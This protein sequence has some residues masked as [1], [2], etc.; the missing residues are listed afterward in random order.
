MTPMTK[1]VKVYH[2]FWQMY[3]DYQLFLLQYR[4]SLTRT[5]VAENIDNSA[6]LKLEFGLSLA[7]MNHNMI[8]NESNPVIGAPFFAA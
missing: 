4:Q 6:Q 8:E 5:V 7:K 2:W 3:G 1:G